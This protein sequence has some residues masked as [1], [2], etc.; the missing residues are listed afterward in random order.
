M[1]SKNRI[2]LAIIS[3]LILHHI[4]N[5]FKDKSIYITKNKL[6]KISQKHPEILV[7]LNGNFQIVINNTFASCDYDEYGLYNFISKVD[8]RYI[9][10]S[11]SSNNFYVEI[12]TMF[13][14]SKRVLRKCNQSIKFL[15]K[16]YKSE[17]L[18]FIK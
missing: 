10:Y 3:T 14:A 5:I 17:F 12:S 11:I 18:Q 16:K 9:L 1:G 7:Y 6:K 15:D 4:R 13:F 2:Y 8:D